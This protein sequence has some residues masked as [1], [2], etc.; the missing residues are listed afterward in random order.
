MYKPHLSN[1]RDAG[2]LLG[3]TVFR[4]VDATFRRHDLTYFFTTRRESQCPLMGKTSFGFYTFYK[5]DCSGDMRFLQ[6][7]AQ[8]YVSP[9][10][11]L[12][13]SAVG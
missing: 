2:V 6:D 8:C 10:E 7:A 3:L 13:V 12:Y 9:L 1:G 11:R 5:V 4:N